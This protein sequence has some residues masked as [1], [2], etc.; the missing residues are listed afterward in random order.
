MTL[1]NVL[2]YER[3]NKLTEI[4]N[5]RLQKEFPEYVSAYQSII[6]LFWLEDMVLQTLKTECSSLNCD[7][8]ELIFSPCTKDTQMRIASISKPC[9]A[10]IAGKLVEMGKLEWDKSIYVCLILLIG[11]ENSFLMDLNKKH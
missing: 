8:L 1:F 7:F 9:T 6:K 11:F 3:S 4:M 2:W 10:A 5:S